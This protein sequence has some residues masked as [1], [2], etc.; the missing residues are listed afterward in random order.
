MERMRTVGAMSTIAW[1]TAAESLSRHSRSTSDTA[2]AAV[3]ITSMSLSMLMARASW[4]V[5]ACNMRAAWVASRG[6]CSAMVMIFGMAARLD[7]RTP[8]PNANRM[9]DTRAAA[10]CTP[11]SRYTHTLSMHHHVIHIEAAVP[12][13]R[14][15]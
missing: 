1:C 9:L 5:M 10:V 15:A 12:H 13:P 2:S 3:H 6:S 4:G 8:A 7:M 14:T 11:Q